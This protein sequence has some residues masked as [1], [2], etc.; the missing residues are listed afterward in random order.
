M[1]LSFADFFVFK[2]GKMIC[3]R[4]DEDHDHEFEFEEFEDY[5]F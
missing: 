1:I 2:L 4:L 3:E 5:E